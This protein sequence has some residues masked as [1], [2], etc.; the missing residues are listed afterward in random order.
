VSESSADRATYVLFALGDEEYGLPVSAVVS[1]IR[2]KTPT[3]VP[4]ASEVVL[5]VVN[6]RGRVL[7]VI[8]LGARF[9]GKP[10]APTSRSR[11]V[12]TESEGGAV[13]IAVDCA[14]EVVTFDAESIQPVP[15]GVLNP[16]TARAV[17][18]MVERPDG[19]VVL[20]DPEETMIRIEDPALSLAASGTVKE[21]E[22]DA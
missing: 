10:F 14:S 16:D 22:I 13:G 9:S 8:N 2:Y 5:G 3:P 11:I 6:L 12:V 20:L 21:E 7:P 17:V 18:G 15:Q 19:M 1:I 4:R